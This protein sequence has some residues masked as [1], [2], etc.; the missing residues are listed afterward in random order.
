M[1]VGI[2]DSPIDVQIEVGPQEG[3]L[4]VTWLPVT[5]T[6]AG[7]SN[8]AVVTG[9][10]I[11]GDGTCF[12]QVPDPTGMVTHSLAPPLTHSPFHPPNCSLTCI[13]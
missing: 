9:Y 11:Y 1:I 10:A 2:P 12:K 5:I 7:L 4:L 3:T 6:N 8:G 13:F